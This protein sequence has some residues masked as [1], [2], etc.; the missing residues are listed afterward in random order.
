MNVFAVV[1]RVLV[2]VLPG[3]A[4]RWLLTQLFPCRVIQG[5]S[6][7]YLTRWTLRERE[8][9]GHDFLHFFHRGDEDR[10]LHD[11]PWA[12]RGL[13]LAW[14]YRE[15]RRFPLAGQG[16]VGWFTKLGELMLTRSPWALSPSYEE[17]AEAARATGYVVLARDYRFGDETDVQPGTFHRV[18]LLRPDLG[19]WTYFTTSPRVKSWSFWNRRTG[20][21]TPW[22]EYLA[23]RGVPAD[24]GT[25]PPRWEGPR[26]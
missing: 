16:D 15:E 26:A 25:R 20:V 6:G 7:P 12:G 18:D 10:D 5:E 19:C 21:L 22:R 11:H 2:A 8:D 17:A 3:R 24:G 13:V 23:R 4:L 1:F 9:G 14:G